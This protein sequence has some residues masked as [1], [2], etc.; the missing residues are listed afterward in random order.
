M[1]KNPFLYLSLC[2][3]FSS[4]NT[5]LP[6]SYYIYLCFS[7]LP[8]PCCLFPPLE[9][10]RRVNIPPG[11]LLP[12]PRFLLSSLL[13]IISFPSLLRPPVTISQKRIGEDSFSSW[14][15]FFSL[16]WF[17]VA[18]LLCSSSSLFFSLLYRIVDFILNRRRRGIG[19]DSSPSWSPFSPLP[20]FVFAFFSLASF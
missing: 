20:W 9:R 19:E 1:H 17:V 13:L 7:P 16:P 5:L 6:I 18:S 14:S 11:Y 8:I 4:F 10:E 15:P 2:T 12:R 3:L